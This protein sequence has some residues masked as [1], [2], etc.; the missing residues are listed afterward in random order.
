MCRT[1]AFIIFINLLILFLPPVSVA[2]SSSY[3]FEVVAIDGENIP[4]IG[5]MTGG[6]GNLKSATGGMAA[7]ATSIENITG[8]GTSI[9]RYD[10]SKPENSRF[11]LIVANL[12]VGQLTWDMS[13]NGDI[14]F[15]DSSLCKIYKAPRGQSASVFSDFCDKEIAFPL[16]SFPDNRLIFGKPSSFVIVVAG[17]IPYVTL[18]FKTKSSAAAPE[19]TAIPQLVKFTNGIPSLANVLGAQDVFQGIP[20]GS[21]NGV[22]YDSYG[23]YGVRLPLTLTTPNLFPTTYI[24]NNQNQ[25]AELFPQY[26]LPTNAIVESYAVSNG[27]ILLCRE[28]TFPLLFSGGNLIPI[29]TEKGTSYDCGNSGQVFLELITGQND[30]KSSLAF[31]KTDDGTNTLLFRSGLRGIYGNSNVTFIEKQTSLFFSTTESFDSYVA[32]GG[33]FLINGVEKYALA[34]A[35]PNARACAAS[36]TELRNTPLT[37]K[38]KA[39]IKSETKSKI[40]AGI[41]KAQNALKKLG[42]SKKDNKKRS[43]INKLISAMKKD[44]KSIRKNNLFHNSEVFL[45]D[46]DPTDSEKS[47]YVSGAICSQL[48]ELQTGLTAYRNSEGLKP[49]EFVQGID[50][51]KSFLAGDIP[52]DTE[53][54]DA[55]LKLLTKSLINSIFGGEVKDLTNEATKLFEVIQKGVKAD[56]EASVIG[57]ESENLAKTL[58]KGF[59]KKKVVK[60]LEGA[61]GEVGRGIVVI[62]EVVYSK[63]DPVKQFEVLKTY[64]HTVFEKFYLDLT[65]KHPAAFAAIFG[66]SLAK[67][68]GD[69]IARDLGVISDTVLTDACL[70]VLEKAQTLPVAGVEDPDATLPDGSIGSFSC[71]FPRVA[72]IRKDTIPSGYFEGFT[73]TLYKDANIPS[74]PGHCLIEITPPS[75]YLSGLLDYVGMG[76]KK[77]YFDAAFVNRKSLKSN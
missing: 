21:L 48:D 46:G 53:K 60:D 64:L 18:N 27:K 39:E 69:S 49:G 35:S 31:Y 75:G 54:S 29:Q 52:K 68:F 45:R 13:D 1:K 14:F 76:E 41:K 51:I 7:F 66:Y 70:R 37:S 50:T 28:K 8:S 40:N 33:Q 34:I 9:V 67:P 72:T 36:G 17:G 22:V 47:D 11:D 44:L 61:V 73:C 26:V 3:H 32:F 10:P 56:K 77:R 16:P 42:R 43:Q 65:K 24:G 20:R 2:D 15:L 63:D 38:E 55:A 5:K 12:P 6:F 30:L 19:A 71:V 57:K 59:A 4:G 58:F 62:A 74:K 25:N 23:L